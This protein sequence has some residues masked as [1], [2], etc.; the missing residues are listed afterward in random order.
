M[1]LGALF[2][3]GAAR[4]IGRVGIELSSITCRIVAL[5]GESPRIRTG[6]AT[7]VS[8]FASMPL[9]SAEAT[10]AMRALRGYRA[11]VVVWNARTEHR[12]VAVVDGTYD[13]MWAEARAALRNDGVQMRGTLADITPAWSADSEPGM[14]A[15]VVA[16]AA[17]GDVAA[18]LRPLLTA[19]VKI[20]AVLTPA[21]ALLS[22][23]RLRLATHTPAGFEAYVALEETEACAAL[24]RDGRLVEVR[25]LPWGY[26]EHGEAHALVRP[27]EEIARRLADDLAVLIERCRQQG[28]PLD[29]V[30]VCGALPD[31]RSMAAELVERLDLVVEPLD[32]LSGIDLSVL[33]GRTEDFRERAAEM[34]LAWAAAADSRPPLDLY[35][36]RQ[37]RAVRRNVARAAVAAGVTAGIGLGWMAQNRWEPRLDVTSVAPRQQPT[38]RRAAQS[39]V[40]EAFSPAAAVIL[41]GPVTSAPRGASRSP[42]G[43]VATASTVTA[44]AVTAPPVT[45][46]A[47]RI[48]LPSTAQAVLERAVPRPAASRFAS[49]PVRQPEAPPAPVPR[50]PVVT[51]RS[52]AAAAPQRPITPPP[53]RAVV[54]AETASEF[55]GMLSMILYGD[56]RRLAIVDGRIVAEG[57]LVKGS[58]VVEIT[59]SAVLFRDPQGRLLR[60]SAGSSGR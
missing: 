32:S 36:T 25:R 10:E 19:G 26:L 58:R 3:S 23:A 12:H 35:R 20:G 45:P 43:D 1:A 42:T 27:R 14:R 34:R 41:Q 4:T 33:A 24:I 38:E 15:L 21:A 46:P 39:P 57:D 8:E 59:S 56:A 5:A 49:G 52:S 7:R 22:L 31:M 2:P 11:D 40:A 54:S 55:D 50:P 28:S 13:Q 6:G 16:T 47:A 29:Q 30:A 51:A 17:V 18:A 48:P 9:L 44:P 53:E 37:R 60:L